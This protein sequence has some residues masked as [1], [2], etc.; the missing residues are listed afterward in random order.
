MPSRAVLL[1]FVIGVAVLGGS[2]VL[3]ATTPETTYTYEAI[4]LTEPYGRAVDSIAHT[5][6]P[7]PDEPSA[8]RIIHIHAEDS[9]ER[10]VLREAANG[11]Y[12]VSSENASLAGVLTRSEYAIM[13]G[14]E[15]GS[16]DGY[17]IYHV[18]RS[19]VDET[20]RL[21]AEQLAIETFYDR[22]AVPAEEEPRRQELVR[23]GNVTTH[24]RLTAVLIESDGRYY[25]IHSRHHAPYRG[26]R[27]DLHHTGYLVGIQMTLF[28][29]AWGLYRR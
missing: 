8:V 27:D 22:L 14:P 26:L 20:V 13:T 10:S 1:V 12:T 7:Y 3:D 19:E 6:P 21:T 23:T 17:E 16:P 29:G 28:A 2:F 24:E 15:S 11:S 18:Q 5:S 25:Y 4:E 9:Q